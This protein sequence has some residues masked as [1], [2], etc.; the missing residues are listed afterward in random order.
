[1]RRNNKQG[2]MAGLMASGVFVKSWHREGGPGFKPHGPNT[3]YTN[4]TNQMRDTW[5][6]TIGPLAL[7]SFA[8][9]TTRVIT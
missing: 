5:R 3:F 6:P 7:F 1:M 2:T 4:T 8:S 9:N